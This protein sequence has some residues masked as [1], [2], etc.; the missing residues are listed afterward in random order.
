MCWGSWC[1]HCTAFYTPEKTTNFCTFFKNVKLKKKVLGRIFNF[2]EVK[3]L[4]KICQNN[5]RFV[6]FTLL[7]IDW[8]PMLCTLTTFWLWKSHDKIWVCSDSENSAIFS[9]TKFFITTKTHTLISVFHQMMPWHQ[10]WQF[11]QGPSNWEP[12]WH[13]FELTC[14]VLFFFAD[15]TAQ[16]FT[17][18]QNALFSSCWAMIKG[19]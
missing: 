17:T 11:L 19:F 16:T 7:R 8:Y 4:R 1:I 12:S 15:W 18:T 14:D 3:M 10:I 2:L 13:G 6:F 5:L 9:T